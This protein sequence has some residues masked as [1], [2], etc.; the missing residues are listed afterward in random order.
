MACAH[1]RWILAM[2]RKR[3]FWPLTA[4][5]ALAGVALALV[6][7]GFEAGWLLVA[8]DDPVMLA[9]R[10]V[11]KRFSAPVAE[12]GHFGITG[13]KERAANI[14]ADFAIQSEN[15]GTRI[16]LKVP[17]PRRQGE[18]WHRV[19]WWRPP[20]KTSIHPGRPA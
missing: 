19:L 20:S 2:A 13:M 3:I 11:D 16:I 9:D 18:F 17:I 12:Q 10:A 6:P 7:D 14:K 1:S 4:A 8:Q 5:L 15:A